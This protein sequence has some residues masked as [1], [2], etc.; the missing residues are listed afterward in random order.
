MFLIYL[1][2]IAVYLHVHGTGRR[3]RLFADDTSLSFSCNNLAFIEHVLYTDLVK[4]K[5]W[6]QQL[7]MKLNP[8]KTEVMV[9]SNLHNDYD[10][11]LKYDENILI[12][13][14]HRKYIGDTLSSNNKLSKHIDSIINSASKKNIITSKTKVSIS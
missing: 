2:D 11:E 7:L 5:D 1:N 4:V 12:I 10:I 9:I 8:L 3:H 6:A 13:V 14:D